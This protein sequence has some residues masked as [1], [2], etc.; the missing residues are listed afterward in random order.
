MKGFTVI[1]VIVKT[2]ECNFS[3]QLE[4]LPPGQYAG[5]IH[6]EAGSHAIAIIKTIDR[7]HFIFDPN[8]GTF[9]IDGE[10]MGTRLESLLKVYDYDWFAFL[11]KGTPPGTLAIPKGLSLQKP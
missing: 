11:H 10:N 5:M 1:S 2:S 4:S 6:H 9:C 8:F 3:C 7:K